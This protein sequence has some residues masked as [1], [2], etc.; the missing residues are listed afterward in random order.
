MGKQ[1]SVPAK[2]VAQVSKGKTGKSAAS[3][4]PAKKGPTRREIGAHGLVPLVGPAMTP[5]RREIGAHGSVALAGTEAVEQDS[6]F[7]ASKIQQPKSQDN[8]CCGFMSLVNLLDTLEQRLIFCGGN[9]KVPEAA[10]MDFVKRTEPMHDD[11]KSGYT[12]GQM[13]S[14]LK[15]LASQGKIKSF[16]FQR[17]KQFS[18]RD[19][20]GPRG[21][22]KRL[23]PGDNLV[24]FGR[25]CKSDTGEKARKK[26]V[27]V[28][29]AAKVRGASA[30]ELA[31]LAL[32]T[33]CKVSGKSCNTANPTHAVGVRYRADEVEQGKKAK[34]ELVDPAKRNAKEL[35]V[36][37]YSV[38]MAELVEANK[39]GEDQYEAHYYVF[40]VEF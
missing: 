32:D 29:Q 17:L 26:T 3:S 30:E 13:Q 39:E 21:L 1:S 4:Q 37:N 31:A 33:Y 19:L 18:V 34:A 27:E 6:T 28:L 15:H 10:F 14:Y 24:V 2:K 40:R 23:R 16:F 11:K 8:N 5:T 35:N 36:L 38:S 25:A 9:L 22:N 12:H 20:L 7:S